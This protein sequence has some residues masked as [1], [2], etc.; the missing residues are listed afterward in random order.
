MASSVVD[1]RSY[2]IFPNS[3]RSIQGTLI[4]DVPAQP[5]ITAPVDSRASGF[6]PGESNQISAA[7]TAVAGNTTY[8]GVFNPPLIVNAPVTIGGFQT[9]ANNGQFTVVSCNQTTL[10]VNNPNGA[11]ETHVATVY[12]DCRVGQNAPPNSRA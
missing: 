11:V 7:A 12:S 6:V 10:V 4:F 2:G 3:P 9:A 1:S 5:S 8:T